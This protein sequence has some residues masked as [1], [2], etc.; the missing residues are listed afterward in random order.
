MLQIPKYGA[1]PNDG[2]SDRAAFMKVLERN[3][4]MKQ[5]KKI[6]QYDRPIYQGKC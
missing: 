3:S 6:P 5:S 1:I 2:K 4:K